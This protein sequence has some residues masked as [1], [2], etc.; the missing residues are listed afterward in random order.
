MVSTIYLENLDKQLIK[1]KIINAYKD[2]KTQ[3]TYYKSRVN[4]NDNQLKNMGA[5]NNKGVLGVVGR[6]ENMPDM[7]DIVEM[8]FEPSE[9]HWKFLRTRPDKETA[10][11]F[12][13]IVSALNAIKDNITIEEIDV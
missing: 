1:G 2:H 12:K 4:L 8:E 3:K 5:V 6:V 7:V 11:A 10:N 9:K 13:T